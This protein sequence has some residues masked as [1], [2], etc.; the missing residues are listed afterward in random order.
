MKNTEKKSI[1]NTKFIVRAGIF[2][3][4][5]SV[6]Y[7]L[8]KFPVPFFPGFLE[9]HFDEVA[10]FIASFAYG[11]FLGLVVLVVKTLIK[12]FFTITMGVGELA[13][14]IYSAAFIMPAAFIYKKNRNFKS[15]IIGLSIGIV[16]QLLVSLILNVYVMI[17]FYSFVFGMSG[18]EL[19]QFVQLTSPKVV[20]IQWSLGVYVIL[21][22][23]AIK[24]ALVI[25][26]TLPTYKSVHKLIDKIIV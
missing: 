11:P 15:V 23:N 7:I 24:D 9:F 1:F 3:A 8:A 25:A 18:E 5:A 4:V 26:L 6:L 14:F 19:L 12:L 10:I 20:D 21:P 22:F 16:S 17:P 2:S 13:D